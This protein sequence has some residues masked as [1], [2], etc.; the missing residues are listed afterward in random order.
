MPYSLFFWILF[1]IFAPTK[2]NNAMH[3]P[4]RLR[5]EQYITIYSCNGSC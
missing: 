5:V 3:D 2:D 1:I 4:G